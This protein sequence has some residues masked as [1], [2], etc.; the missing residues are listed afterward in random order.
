M[1]IPTI[2]DLKAKIG[3]AGGY[4]NPSLYYVSLPTLNLNGEQK[5]SIEFFVKSI[6]LPSRSLLTVEREMGTDMTKVAYGYQND[7]ITMTLLVMNDHL[8]RQYIENWQQFIVKDY[9]PNV[10][11]NFAIGYPDDYM[12]DIRIFQL[13]RGAGF[14]IVGTQRQID[15]GIININL[16]AKVDLRQSASVKYTWHLMDAFPIAFQQETLSN[17]ATGTIS[18]IT[19]TFSYRKWKGYQLQ[20]GRTT[21]I[22][23]STSVT[24]DIG[25]QIGGKIYDVIGR[26]KRGL[27]I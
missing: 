15:A 3:A 21:G 1:K 20:G 17:D 27:R 6:S 26:I 12:R 5:Q 16:G 2:D 18:E 19:V 4:A 13:D 10:E 22:D 7:D 24:T 25:Q 8:T 11:N 14:P 23:V 9:N